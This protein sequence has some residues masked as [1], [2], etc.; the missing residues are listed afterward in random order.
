MGNAAFAF[1][2]ACLAFTWVKSSS[3][4]PHP[5]APMRRK[6]TPHLCALDIDL[7]RAAIPPS[8]HYAPLSTHS[9]EDSQSD[10]DKP[11]LVIVLFTALQ[12]AP[13]HSDKTQALV[14]G[15]QGSVGPCPRAS[16][17]TGSC[18]TIHFYS[19]YCRPNLPTFSLLHTPQS[20]TMLG[21]QTCSSLILECCSHTLCMAG[22][23]SSF[24]TSSALSLTAVL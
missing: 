5:D 21:L 13:S 14:L 7:A 16:S 24:T 1:I 9:P 19:L 18:A 12:Q 6:Y 10:F 4:K 22:S 2:P 20:S 23:F 8:F 17:L 15:L 3:S 11:R